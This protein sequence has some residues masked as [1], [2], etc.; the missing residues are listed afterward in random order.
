MASTTARS[1]DV[2]LAWNCL[3]SFFSNMVGYNLDSLKLSLTDPQMYGVL[4]A[5]SP[6]LFPTKERGT[7]NAL[8][9]AANRVFGIMVSVTQEVGGK[10][11]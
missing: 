11:Y 7:G 5:L 10:G 9:A 1:S 8:T 4:Y 6:E 3:Y 2:L